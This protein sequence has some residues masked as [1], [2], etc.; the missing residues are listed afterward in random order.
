MGSCPGNILEY[1]SG[2]PEIS[3]M[4]SRSSLTKELLLEE[5]ASSYWRKTWKGQSSLMKQQPPHVTSLQEQVLAVRY[6]APVKLFLKVPAVN[7]G[8]WGNIGGGMKTAT[9][10]KD[11][12]PGVDVQCTLQNELLPEERHRTCLKFQICRLV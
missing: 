6:H 3:V 8:M 5:F 1:R 12:W 4:A 11:H 7:S 9:N 2:V 10:F